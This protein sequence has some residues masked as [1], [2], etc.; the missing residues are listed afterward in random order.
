[1]AKNYY[2][3][4]QLPYLVWGQDPPVTSEAYLK[5]CTSLLSPED[6]SVVTALSGDGGEEAAPVTLTEAVIR[7]GLPEQLKPLGVAHAGA[8]LGFNGQ[9]AE[10]ERELKLTLAALRA[11]KASFASK[12]IPP[13]DVRHYAAAE[14]AAKAA[15][16]TENPLEAE[17]IVDKAR[18]DAACNFAGID[19]FSLDSVCA[20]YVKLSIL[21]REAKFETERGFTNY[22]KIYDGVL[23]AYNNKE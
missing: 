11:S 8:P 15:A 19:T 1:M 23:K 18:W 5:Q 14:N 9:W 2:F 7:K 13:V 21:E 16:A 22:R 17:R 10:F 3:V 4:S 12:D 20:Y 6:A